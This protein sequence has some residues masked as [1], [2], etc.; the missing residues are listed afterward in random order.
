MGPIRRA[1]LCGGA[2]ALVAGVAAIDVAVG[3][4]FS[5]PGRLPGTGGGWQFAVNDRGQAVGVTAT[6]GKLT[7][8]SFGTT[9]RVQRQWRVAVP[10]AVEATVG[11]GGLAFDDGGRIALALTYYDGREPPAEEEHAGPGCC[12]HTAVVSWQLGQRP[13]TPQTVS[14][15]GSAQ[16]PSQGPEDLPV[17]V[18]GRSSVT[19]LWREGGAT[20]DGEGLP[21]RLAQAFGPFGG[22]LHARLLTRAPRGIPAYALVS[23]RNGTPIAGWLDDYNR[24]RVAGGNA[25]GV[26][27]VKGPA[28][29]IHA[30]PA[31]LAPAPLEGT[32]TSGAPGQLIYA[33]ESGREN[34]TR[35]LLM[36]TSRDAHPFAHRRV[37]TTIPPGSGHSSLV[38]G[39]SGSVLALWEWF[40]PPF[41][42]HFHSRA[43]LG[44]ISGRF[45][46]PVRAGEDGLGFVGG[47]GEGIV[48]YRQHLGH[49]GHFRLMVITA[50]RGH[51]FGA[52][53]RF[54][55]LHTDCGLETGQELAIG[56]VATSRNGH[57]I[58]YTSCESGQ[59]VIRYTP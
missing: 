14:P 55:P 31:S 45:A 5:L 50:K 39:N 7:I 15:A 6:N 9:T 16:E 53:R 33:L 48:I 17:V 27:S 1:L 57:A 26:L 4:Q 13:P 30:T 8:Y 21:G 23:A 41:T 52:A 18:L 59:Y 2:A 58:L 43:S 24:L 49:F 11:S 22:P 38:A 34:H 12:Y 56:P 36:L 37:V 44:G 54:L 42:L 19:A 28:Q 32:F 25:R 40:G 51:R 3:A 20:E 47:H 10:G 46:A 29:V 35:R